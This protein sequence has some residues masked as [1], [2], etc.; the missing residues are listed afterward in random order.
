LFDRNLNLGWFGSYH[1]TWGLKLVRLPSGGW[2]A[3]VTK[4]FARSEVGLSA[5]LV[6]C[7][8]AHHQ[9]LHQWRFAFQ[10]IAS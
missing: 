9:R 4:A 6:S 3:L 1:H 5:I 2:K 7:H 8:N 10:N